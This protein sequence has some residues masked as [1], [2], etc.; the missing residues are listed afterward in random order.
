MTLVDN[1]ALATANWQL[2]TSDYHKQQPDGSCSCAFMAAQWQ[3]SGNTVDTVELQWA[4]V[5]HCHINHR[6]SAINFDIAAM[7][8]AE[9]AAK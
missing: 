8:A 9:A 1:D 7:R 4:A 3:H 6:A 2:A 5:P